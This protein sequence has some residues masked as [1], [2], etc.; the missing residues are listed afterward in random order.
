MIR[1][2]QQAQEYAA[3]RLAKGQNAGELLDDLELQFADSDYEFVLLRKGD[4][5][6]IEIVYDDSRPNA[7][8]ATLK[9]N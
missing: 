5:Q 9:G 7:V 3:H 8:I 4:K 1:I 2:V 6:T